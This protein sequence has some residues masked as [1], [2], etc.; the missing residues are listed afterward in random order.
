MLHLLLDFFFS[1]LLLQEWPHQAPKLLNLWL[2][3]AFHSAM[4][5][6][7][8]TLFQNEDQSVHWQMKGGKGGGLGL[9]A[10]GSCE[11]PPKGGIQGGPSSSTPLAQCTSPQ[12][13]WG[14]QGT[15]R[16]AGCWPRL[17]GG[18]PITLPWGRDQHPPAP[19]QL[20]AQRGQ[21]GAV[22]LGR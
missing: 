1:S 16:G 15:C 2:S 12:G 17:W 9:P 8:P 18:C 11:A 22:E 5:I 6:S 21:Q 10:R 4:G 13:G 20:R 3:S 19:V 14:K 7:G